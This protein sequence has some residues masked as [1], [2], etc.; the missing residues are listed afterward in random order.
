MK[1]HARFL[2]YID[3]RVEKSKDEMKIAIIVTVSCVAITFLTFSLFYNNFTT[4]NGNIDTVVASALFGGILNLAVGLNLSMLLFKWFNCKRC[5][6]IWILFLN[7]FSFGKEY[8][9]TNKKMQN[10]IKNN[11]KF[12]EL[13]DAFLEN[14]KDISFTMYENSNN[15]IVIW[16]VNENNIK[17]EFNYFDYKVLKVLSDII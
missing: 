9:I 14:I 5:K 12:K 8:K 6:K 11:I 1:Q 2:N 4:G 17:Q 13:N 16:N 15:I 7:D 10:V 3:E